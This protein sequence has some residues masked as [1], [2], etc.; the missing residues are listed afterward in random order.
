[1]FPRRFCRG[2]VPGHGGALSWDLAAPWADAGGIYRAMLG[3]GHQRERAG[4]VPDHAALG[5]V[6]V[7]QL[8]SG[9]DVLAGRTSLPGVFDGDHYGAAGLD[10]SGAGPHFARDDPAPIGGH[11]FSVT[12]QN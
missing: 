3:I 9:H 5:V 4:E 7:H 1:M 2:G 6:G 11:H 12:R 8:G 10:F